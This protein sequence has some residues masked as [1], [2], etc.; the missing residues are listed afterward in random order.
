MADRGQT[1]ANTD[2]LD[3]LWPTGAV[4]PSILDEA[5][6]PRFLLCDG[7]RVS[8]TTY[9]ALWQKLG[10]RFEVT[11]G[12]DPGD[13]LFRVPPMVENSLNDSDARI[14]AG[15]DPATSDEVGGLTGQL[16]HS[17]APGTL[18][19]PGHS[20]GVGT[21]VLPGHGH[22]HSFGSN[23]GHTL[24]SD[25]QPFESFNDDLADGT[26]ESLGA[27]AFGPNNPYNFVNAANPGVAGSISNVG[28]LALT[29]APGAS[30]GPHAIS[31]ATD[32]A[33]PAYLTINWYVKT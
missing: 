33:D 12:V 1:L 20:H 7:R 25:A 6:M 31:G 8:K 28:D 30:T 24:F 18:A 16:G 19:M 23:H 27:G 3:V 17:H 10:S 9:A 4:I 29:G 13:G 21:L 15:V 14:P 11:P 2:V 26:Y 32:P 5:D 22:S